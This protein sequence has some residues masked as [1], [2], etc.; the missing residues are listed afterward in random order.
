M[1]KILILI[2]LLTGAVTNKVYSQINFGIKGGVVANMYEL[3]F[4]NNIEDVNLS[5]NGKNAAFH[6][7]LQL[8]YRTKLGLY[9]QSDVLYSYLPEKI[10]MAF[11][12]ENSSIDIER[13]GL[14]IPVL[15][16]FKLA[17]FRIYAG[18]KFYIHLDDNISK[19]LSNS[20]GI[21]YDFG[22]EIF[23]YQVGIGFDII[24]RVTIDLS[25]NGRFAKS[26][27]DIMVDG[28]TIHGKQTNSQL[29]LSVGFLF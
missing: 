16:G 14:E 9:V 18:P 24:N 7:G 10:N 20:A 8:R 3:N 29:W 5:Q 6:V 17:F 2:V 13:H 11:E 28:N 25:Y 12:G 19:S 26:A 21:G 27:H 23:G 15:V 1:K 22:D 4:N